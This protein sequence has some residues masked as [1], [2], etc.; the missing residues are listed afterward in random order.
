[1]LTLGHAF[2]FLGLGFFPLFF[3]LLDGLHYSSL[4]EIYLQ[5]KTMETTNQNG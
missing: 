5:G 1:V 2:L 4:Q 3:F